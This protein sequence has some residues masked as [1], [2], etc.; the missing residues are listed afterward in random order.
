MHISAIN[1]K[2][3]QVMENNKLAFTKPLIVDQDNIEDGKV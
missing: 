1:L 2:R 3:K